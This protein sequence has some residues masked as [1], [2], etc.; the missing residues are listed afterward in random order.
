MAANPGGLKAPNDRIQNL[1][2]FEQGNFKERFDL[3]RLCMPGTIKA[4]RL[5]SKAV[6]SWKWVGKSHGQGKTELN[7]FLECLG[8]RDSHFVLF[9]PGGRWKHREKITNSTQRSE[10]EKVPSL[11]RKIKILTLEICFNVSCVWIV[12][13]INEHP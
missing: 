5:P 4:T 13:L 9:S 8:V 6:Y 3:E 1:Q 12:V 2:V 11:F 10:R 7:E